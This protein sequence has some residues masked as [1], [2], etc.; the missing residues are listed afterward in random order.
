MKINKKAKAIFLGDSGVGKSAIFTR[1]TQNTFNDYNLSTIG[2]ICIPKYHINKEKS[3]QIKITFWDTA[4]QERFRAI[5]KNEIFGANIVIF[6]C[7]NEESFQMIK[8]IWYKECNKLINLSSCL[9]LLLKTK[10]DIK[11]ENNDILIKDMKEYAN[12]IGAMFFETSAKENVNISSLYNYIC[13]ESEKLELEND[14]AQIELNK[15][16]KPSKSGFCC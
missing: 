10:S 4:G 12:Q 7:H 3:L 11:L 14:N 13:F 6:C 9:K 8:D 5:T 2:A 1:I 15:R 16:D